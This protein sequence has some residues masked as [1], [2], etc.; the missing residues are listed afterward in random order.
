METQTFII[1]EAVPD[2]AKELLQVMKVI[3]RETPFLIMDEEGMNLS[4][5]EMSVN[6]E[7]LYACENNVFMVALA[8][9]KIIGTASVKASLKKR[10]E[11]IGELGISI[12]KEYWGYGLGN[13]LMEELLM[14]AKDSGVIRRVELTVQHRNQRAIHLY[15]KIG[16][17]TEAIMPRGAKTDD[18]E[19]LDVHL[20]SLMI[21]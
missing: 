19:F 8:D 4:I 12:L 3:G 18:G 16:F 5:D 14:W 11:H 2:D 9:D 20:M 21:D 1:R 6:L 17:Q 15:E 7:K 10:M 13:L